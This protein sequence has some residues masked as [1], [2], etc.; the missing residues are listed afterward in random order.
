MTT[1]ETLLSFGLGRRYVDNLLTLNT[2]AEC[3]IKVNGALLVPFPFESGIR[4][5]CPVSSQLY[6]LCIEPFLC[7]M[8]RLTGIVA[9]T[10]PSFSLIM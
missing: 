3:L 1:F 5:G 7:L 9:V 4:Q 8:R 2:S 10:F 6:S